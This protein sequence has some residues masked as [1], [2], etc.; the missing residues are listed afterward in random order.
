MAM[1]KSGLSDAMKAALDTEFGA[2][3]DPED[4]GVSGD[5]IRTQVCDAL[6]D[7]IV[8]YLTSNAAVSTTSGCTAG[9]AVATGSLS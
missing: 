8:S 2:A 3:V 9:G 4:E 5:S 7:A 6:A 1:T